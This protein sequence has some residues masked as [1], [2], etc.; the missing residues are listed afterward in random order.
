V[1]TKQTFTLTAAAPLEEV[2]AAVAGRLDVRLDI[3]REALDA[4][5]IALRE[6][7]RV[8]VQDASAAELLEA[9]LSPLKLTGKVVGGRLEIRGAVGP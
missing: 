2:L 5:G 1:K 6:I 4:R 8:E 7:V 9:V 3:D